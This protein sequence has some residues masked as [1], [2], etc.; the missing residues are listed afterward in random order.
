MRARR[1]GSAARPVRVLVAAALAVGLVAAAG[2]GAKPIFRT[3]DMDRA[4]S[5]PSR[6]ST[7]APT[8]SRPSSARVEEVASAWLGTPYRYGGVD[9]RGID[10]SA[11]VQNVMG[12][13]G[14]R[15]PRTTRAQLSTGRKIPAS[16]GFRS[17]DLLFFRLESTHVNHVAIAL[18]PDRFIH[19]SSSRGVVVDRLMD[20]YFGRRL[21][22]ARRVLPDP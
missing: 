22:E 10:C 4:A 5:A 8:P 13:L 11:L 2:C 15:V 14:A 7:A 9:E 12:D 16:G 1:A 18:G 20:D 21:V 17:G 3:G 6:P 19:A